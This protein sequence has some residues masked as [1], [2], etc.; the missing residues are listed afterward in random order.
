MRATTV[1]DSQSGSESLYTRS[2]I[3][4]LAAQSCY[5][6]SFSTFFL[7]PKYLK[8]SLHASDVQIGAVGAIGAVAGVLAFPLVGSLNDRFGRKRFM[9]LG[10][11]LMTLLALSMLV[12]TRVDWPLYLAR[13]GHGLSFAL[14]Y[15]SATTLVSERVRPE[16]LGIA[17][18][19]FGS[20]VLIT[21]ALA[22][23]LAELLANHHSWTLVFWISG[24]WGVLSI[25]LTLLVD[26]APRAALALPTIS[27]FGMLRDP[28]ARTVAIAI[29]GAG[30]GFGTVFTF[31]Q[32]Y[33]LRVG[34]E[35]VSGFFVAYATTAL[36]GRMVLLARIDRFDRQRV[37]AVSMAVY[38]VAVF[39][40]AWLRP[41]MLEV[42]GAVLGAAHGLL[43]PVFNALAMQRVRPE[44]RGSLMALYHGGFNGGM[45][46]ALL[47]G[48]AI[49]E[50]LSYP[51]L[52]WLT[53]AC[54]ALAA[55]MLWRS[56]LLRDERKRPSR[57]PAAS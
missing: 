39:A 55:V 47:V 41:I 4:L 12:F 22:P 36:F 50:Q 17:L 40:T 11:A 23:A 32:P 13:L 9:L 27:G 14:F 38:A 6:M 1:D 18:G 24:A 44:E 42:I 57:R 15:N 56:P 29:A 54:T 48:G 25:L 35:Q 26:E 43:Y 46:L 51:A 2:F 20:S 10:S 33:A 49:A 30:A 37:S 31:H 3:I 52:F 16:R 45:A 8:L 34:I 5:G 21:N 53:G 28:R 7:L 19:V